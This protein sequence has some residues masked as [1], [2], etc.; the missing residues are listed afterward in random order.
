VWDLRTGTPLKSLPTQGGPIFTVAC[1]PD[2]RLLASGGMDAGIRLWDA[3]RG[4][5]LQALGAVG[6]EHDT[7]PMF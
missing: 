6:R 5:L 1:S 7:P 3:E 2:G 4:M